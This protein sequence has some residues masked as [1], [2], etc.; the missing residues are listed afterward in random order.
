MPGRAV[1]CHREDLQGEHSAAAAVYQPCIAV[2]HFGRNHVQAHWHV[3]QRQ[4]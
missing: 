4:D 3:Q 2:R 1:P